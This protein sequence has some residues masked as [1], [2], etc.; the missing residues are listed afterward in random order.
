MMVY[1]L[2]SLI[3]SKAFQLCGKKHGKKK[4]FNGYC[5]ANGYCMT[6]PKKK[7]GCIEAYSTPGQCK[8]I[9]CG[10]I[11]KKCPEGAP[12]CSGIKFHF[13]EMNYGPEALPEIQVGHCSI[14]KYKC[15]PLFS[16][17]GKCSSSG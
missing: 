12:Y 1:L 7:A 14:I 16:M 5:S 2:L 13:I 6:D 9:P 17:N 8:T 3:S 11:Y 15:N 4:C 10:T